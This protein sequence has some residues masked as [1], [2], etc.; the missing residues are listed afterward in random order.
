MNP[1][2]NAER[3]ILF[4]RFISIKKAILAYSFSSIVDILIIT[5]ISRIFNDISN[6][7]NK[8]DL[9]DSFLQ[10][11][12]L[13][14]LRT[15]LVFIFRKFS[16]NSL[17][18]KKKE[19]EHK[20]VSK[21]V[22]KRFE[23]N[24]NDLYAIEHFKE[25]LLNS[26]NLATINFDIP[27]VSI[28]SEFIFAI[29]GIFILINIFGLKIFIFNFPALFLLIYFSKFI[30]K[31]LNKF[32][33]KIIVLT[34]KR[35]RVIDNISELSLEISVLKKTSK[36]SKYLES[37]NLPYNK[38][39]GQQIITSNMMQLTTESTSFL[40]I[41]ISLFCLVLGIAEASLSESAASLVVLSRMVPSITRSISF[42]AQLQFG[43][44]CVIN[45]SKQKI[46]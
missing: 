5:S 2:L 25:K 45:L 42:F 41:L 13:I 43:I 22:E 20:I 37:I 8:F 39:I 32:G 23:S 15:L 11:I 36:L 1:F 7:N 46:I 38:L 4:K 16:I 34:E 30:A 17:L 29:G 6:N 14:C 28:F 3:N 44:P 31:R 24:L 10:C 12:F 27:I 21:F 40:I 26:S 18:M 9:T 33:K 19:D 35:L